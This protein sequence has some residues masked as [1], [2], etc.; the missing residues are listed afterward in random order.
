MYGT[1]YRNVFETMQVF[2]GSNMSHPCSFETLTCLLQQPSYDKIH[3]QQ[4]SGAYC[5]QDCHSISE[6]RKHIAAFCVCS[7]P[8]AMQHATACMQAK[9]VGNATCVGML[10]PTHEIQPYCCASFCC[11]VPCLVTSCA[12]S[13]ISR[14]AHQTCEPISKKVDV[15]WMMTTCNLADL[16]TGSC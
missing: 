2:E 4:L 10:P 1:A 15:A 5:R 13:A 8:R 7:L 9:T 6:W 16:Q 14:L 12:E 11:N 3:Q